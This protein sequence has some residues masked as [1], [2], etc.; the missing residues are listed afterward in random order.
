[1]PNYCVY[2]K[3]AEIGILQCVYPW[4]RGR[5]VVG[6]RAVFL[7]TAAWNDAFE[8]M[9]EA[10]SEE[11]WQLGEFPFPKDMWDH[12]NWRVVDET[13]RRWSIEL[14]SIC[15]DFDGAFRFCCEWS[16]TFPE[17]RKGEPGAELMVGHTFRSTGNEWA[18]AAS[19]IVLSLGLVFIMSKPPIQIGW[20]LAT[21]GAF[22]AF[23][24]WPVDAETHAMNAMAAAERCA[25]A[26]TDRKMNCSSE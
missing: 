24:L 1:M 14:P 7:P 11:D 5:T 16:G 18:V 2:W 4:A 8:K 15:R 22:G 26:A 9:F 21:L 12:S 20:V 25:Q 6:L 10:I 3:D 23:Y 13:G 17:I 19:L